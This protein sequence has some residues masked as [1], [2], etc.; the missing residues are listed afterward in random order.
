MPDNKFPFAPKDHGDETVK[1]TV[2]IATPPQTF[3]IHR[4]LI[5]SASQFF[6]KAFNGD[7]DESHARCMKLPHESHEAFQAL[8]H[9]LYTGNLFC[10]KF[11]MEPLIEE[12]VYWLHIYA[13]AD[14]LLIH[15]LS[16]DTYSIIRN[17]FSKK[18]KKKNSPCPAY[19]SSRSFGV[20]VGC[21]R[22]SKSSW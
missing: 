12:D 20:I 11:L 8:Y 4:N 2:G 19:V 15:K 18:K 9:W 21:H 6:N 1:I 22:A 16:L 17:Y 10:K 7:F 14:N 3:T 13:M 5:C